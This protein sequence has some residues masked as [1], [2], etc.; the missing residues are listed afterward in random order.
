MQQDILKS[1]NEFGNTTLEAAKA[2]NEINSKFVE[3][4]IKQQLKAADLFVAGSLQQAK[5]AQDVRETKDFMAKQAALT[6]EFTA[7]FVDLAKANAT[8]AQEAGA[9]Y[10]AW[11]EKGMKQADTTVKS[12]AKKAVAAAA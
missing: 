8:L 10:K 12:V 4:T 1:L 5:L 3:K 6:E 11:I 7:K 2:L 9:E